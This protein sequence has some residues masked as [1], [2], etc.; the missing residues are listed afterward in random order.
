MSVSDITYSKHGAHFHVAFFPD[1]PDLQWKFSVECHC[2]QAMSTPCRIDRQVRVLAKRM[3]KDAQRM[4]S[5][6]EFVAELREATEADM[7]E[8][9]KEVASWA[10]S[11]S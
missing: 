2:S 10:T 7:A 5:D 6:K 1:K 11:K 9:N 3:R 4:V 8:M